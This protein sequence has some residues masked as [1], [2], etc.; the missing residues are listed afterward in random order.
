MNATAQSSFPLP[1]VEE[2]ADRIVDRRYRVHT[3]LVGPRSSEGRQTA[4]CGEAVEEEGGNSR[5]EQACQ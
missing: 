5:I 3:S 1:L 2:V 4:Q